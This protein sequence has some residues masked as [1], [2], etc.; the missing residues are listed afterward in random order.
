MDI[1]I[2]ASL[3][4]DRIMDFQGHFKD[5]IMPDK[6]HVLSVCFTVDKLVEKKGGVASNIAYTLNLLG[7]KSKIVATAGSDFDGYKQYLESLNIATDGIMIIKEDLTASARIITDKSD[8]QITAFH[9]GAMNYSH[10]INLKDIDFDKTKAI[11]LV[12]P[13][14]KEGMIKRSVECKEL[15]IPYIFDPGQQL[16]VFNGEELKLLIDGAKILIVNDYELEVVQTKTGLSLEDLLGQVET[17]ITTLGEKGSVIYSGGNKIEIPPVKVANSIDPTGAGDAY[18][19]GLLKGLVNG[20]DWE[21]TGRTA[22]LCGAYAVEKYGTQEHKYSL[23]E[24]EQRFK[25]S[26]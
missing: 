17:L 7:E 12:G 13:D 16:N 15:N 5:H 6:I 22:S 2:S 8:N 14:G 4:F 18:R 26:F 20:W 1:I 25:E 21:K 23:E 3:A 19:A 10:L 24:F 11:V 9:P